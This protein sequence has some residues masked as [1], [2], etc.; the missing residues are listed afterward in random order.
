[1]IGSL[2]ATSGISIGY[3]TEIELLYDIYYRVL[4]MKNSRTR[5]RSSNRRIKSTYDLT[6]AGQH[7]LRQ[8]AL[9]LVD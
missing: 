5:Y 4:T 9:Y 7:R 6:G 1:M 2:A 3:F 8:L